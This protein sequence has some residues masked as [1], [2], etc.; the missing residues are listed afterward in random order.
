M[1]DAGLVG[2]VRL[3]GDGIEFDTTTA[4]TVTQTADDAAQSVW[5]L[6]DIVASLTETGRCDN[7]AN[8]TI[9]IAAYGLHDEAVIEARV[10]LADL[11]SFNSGSLSEEEFIDR[12]RYL[13]EASPTE[14]TP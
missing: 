8:I 3:T 1:A 6:L 9:R 11:E 2:T 12:V 14:A 5:T 7:I 10:A 13:V 4:L